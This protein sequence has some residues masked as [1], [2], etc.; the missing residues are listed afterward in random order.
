MVVGELKKLFTK[1]QHKNPES[2]EDMS[3]FQ[4]PAVSPFNC[5]GEPSTISQR[6]EK[7]VKS[8]TYFI[9]A[10]G[11][12]FPE[13]RKALL[14][15]LLG[16]ETQEI[17]ET[18]NV[19]DGASLE[20]A[21]EAL[22]NYFVV[23]KNVPFERSIFHQA[24]QKDDES[25]EQ[26]VTRLRTLA[27]TCDYGDERDNQIRDQLIAACK[28]NTFRKK[29][30]SKDNLT[31]DKALEMG[32]LLENV[33]H[34]T[35]TIDN[36]GSSGS[37]GDDEYVNFMKGSNR[38]TV[39]SK[40]PY[41]RSNASSSSASGRSCGR[42]GGNGHISKDCRR[43]KDSSCLKCGKRGHWKVMCRTKVNTNSSQQSGNNTNMNVKTLN[44]VKDDSS[45]DNDVYVF[46][47]VISKEGNELFPILCGGQTIDLLIDSGSKLNI[48]DENKFKKLKPVPVS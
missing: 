10:S 30:L 18:L 48:L 26:F 35:K 23:K 5:H 1:R 34:Q 8:F 36:Q 19:D 39:S 40:F 33:L 11:V 29:L 14:L 21:L 47:M 3:Q 9:K 42:C 7:W 27:A 17:F 32:Q 24:K 45:D 22:T 46:P 41:S 28:S 44:T 25:I 2:I 37:K 12:V 31:L 6:W 15:H 20:V 16:R 4:I 38:K 13:R 43:T